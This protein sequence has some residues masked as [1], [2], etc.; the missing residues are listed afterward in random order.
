MN[1]VTTLYRS[2]PLDEW[3]IGAL[4]F[5][6]PFERIPSFNLL[7]A[8]LRL[9]YIVAAVIILR[10]V[11]VLWNDKFS[12]IRR[13]LPVKILLIFASWIVVT[14]PAS[15][16]IQR[17]LQVAL[18]T[19]IVIATAI[20]LRVL[21]KPAYLS[22]IIKALLISSLVVGVFGI[23]QYFANLAGVPRWLTGMRKLYDWQ[24][25]G[26]PRIHSTALEPL[27]YC[28]YLLI[29]ISYLLVRSLNRSGV[30]W[31]H[32]SLLTLLS[33][34]VVLTVSRGGIV[35]LAIMLCAAIV[36][37]LI[38]RI[39]SAKRIM[40]T[41]GILAVAVLISLT[42]INFVSREPQNKKITK[43]QKGAAGFASQ[44]EKTDLENSGDD[45]ALM[46]KRAI[47]IYT[48]DAAHIF[49]GVGPGQ[50]G[51]YIQNNVPD[52]ANGWKIVN[53]ETLELLVEYGLVGAL[54]LAAFVLIVVS[55][56]WKIPTNN[57]RLSS[58]GLGLIL[59][60]VALAVQYQT[61]STLY[62]MHVWVVLGLQM[63][64]GVQTRVK[65]KP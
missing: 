14:I 11:V 27:Y 28:S 65:P 13:D 20:A 53:N 61:F 5:L 12:T 35:A 3:L 19:L 17:G 38:K 52:R 10:A 64:F 44:L 43:G 25:F 50:F 26:F 55:R 31:K 21:Y 2:K 46:R 59:Y 37:M 45:R 32:V 33:G 16:N 57:L 29:P 30:N 1:K 41:L 4:V 54:L 15:I 39:T 63:A 49:I 9:S 8:S 7:G 58:M 56:A 62:I 47:S 40:S 34:S 60:L 18:Y 48:T 6:L 42:M 36:V 22:T 51:P 23:Y 24:V